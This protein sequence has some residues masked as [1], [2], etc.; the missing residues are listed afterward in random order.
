MPRICRDRALGTMTFQLGPT[1]HASAEVGRPI[2][3]RIRSVSYA[4]MAYWYY[5]WDWGESV[6]VDGV[7]LAAA[8]IDELASAWAD[9]EVDAW[10]A[11]CVNDGHPISPLGPVWAVVR[12]L[13][14][15]RCTS[16]DQAT[17]LVRRLTG[18]VMSA[19]DES[20]ALTPER[21]GSVYVDSLYGLP[22]AL[23]DHA[24]QADDDDLLSRLITI[25]EHHTALL[26]NRETGLL[27]HYAP[28]R[29]TGPD[30]RWGRGNG[31]GALGLADLV[32]C[33]GPDRSPELT[34]RLQRLLHSLIRFQCASGEWRNLL[35]E[36]HSYPEAST[37]ALVTAALAV[38]APF[39]DLPGGAEARERGWASVSDRIDT[40]GHVY[41]VSYRPGVNT[42]PA[43][44]E[45]TPAVGSYPWGQGAWLRAAAVAAT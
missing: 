39:I 8:P 24:I 12:R 7:D 26:Q 10:V 15:G 42:D 32:A 31:W 16:P 27:A 1:S 45:H 19:A 43:R 29:G 11:R 38:A 41:G 35:D 23:A 25:T 5:R 3:D 37:T 22:V 17:E 14:G 13:V 28:L 34:D 20:G 33:V 40:N 18:E 4:A 2:D 30:I 44:Y 9:R 6:A 21:S 36:E